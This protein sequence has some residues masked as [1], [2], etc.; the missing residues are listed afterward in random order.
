M[1]D[2]PL[3]LP[4]GSPFSHQQSVALNALL[5]TLS[6]SQAAWLS[7]F[8]A[9][10]G[11]LPL[12]PANPA[13]A[14]L[15]VPPTTAPIPASPAAPA[16]AAVPLTILFGS[17]SGNSEKCANEAL[18]AAVAA[19]FA[20][21]VSDVATFDCAQLASV[22]NLLLVISTWGEGDPPQTATTFYETLLSPKA[23][24]LAKLRFAVCALGDTSYAEFCATGKRCDERFAELGGTRIANRVD[25]D[26]DFEPPFRAWLAGVI[27]AMADA[28]GLSANLAA[29]SATAV[30]APSITVVEAA[31]VATPA[32]PAAKPA[33]G[34]EATHSKN[35]PFAA[36]LLER[37]QLNGRGSK[38]ET[39]HLEISLA[40]SGIEY[41]PGDALAVIPTNCP[42][43]V[44]D[45]LRLAGF[46]G[47]EIRE[48]ADGR[49]TSLA[50][51]LE[52]DYD[53]TS[54]NPALM[55]KFAAIARN[56]QLDSFLGDD[57]KAELSGWLYG[58][59]LRDL[60]LEFPPSDPL[61][62]EQF[63]GLM[64]KMPPRLYSIA[65]SLRAHPNEIHLTVGVVRYEAH[66][67]ARKGVC[68]TYL[69]ERV[70]KGG[71]M[72]VYNHHNKNFFLPDNPDTPIIM[73][74]PGTG[75]APFRSFVEERAA[76]GAKGRNWLFFGDQHFNTDFLYQLEWQDYLKSGVLSRLDL[77]FSRD[78]DRKVY[79]QHRMQEAAAE[80]YA[81]LQE[82]AYFYVCGEAARMAKDVHQA[83]ID[84]YVSV[85]GLSS[86]AAEAT[87][88]QLQKDKR[89]Q[90]DVY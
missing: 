45:L 2:H 43:V 52:T 14:N 16:A 22:E 48:A 74:G 11:S 25:C 68:S 69:A 23:P 10:A 72:L 80:I 75:I 15:A 61:S 82:G 1:S 88:K 83:L 40:G 24:A 53:I 84:I 37:L 12:K 20:A 21:K 4:S 49:V 67:K 60:Y 41:K 19:G 86:E 56:P 47:D 31:A 30:A 64:R 78:T 55:K 46:R 85:G 51:A 33:A 73:V 63:V 38:K 57:R 32:A 90:R 54:L 66:G 62:V 70:D 7:G 26:V 34:H 77:A 76:T 79:V 71:T 29:A 81:W 13:A 65:S 27:P 18:K 9:A 35:N 8:F 3:S 50:E 44:D 87:V 58:R 28:S 6:A 59:E 36:P 17:E 5:P 39:V 89:Y 42:Q